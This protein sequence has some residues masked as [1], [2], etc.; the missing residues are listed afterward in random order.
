MLNLVLFNSVLVVLLILPA[1]RARKKKSENPGLR[2]STVKSVGKVLGQGMYAPVTRSGRLIVDGALVS[3]FAVP[4]YAVDPVR[5]HPH[6][7]GDVDLERGGGD[8][9]LADYP[10]I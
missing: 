9:G 10:D 7:D 8:R 5:E 1:R 2:P 6:V 4:Q 3:S